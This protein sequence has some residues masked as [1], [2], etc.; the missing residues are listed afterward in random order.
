MGRELHSSVVGILGLAPTAHTLALMLHSLGAKL[1]GYD[2]A[3]HHTAPIWG[4]LNV[5]PVSQQEL[6]A[7][8]TPFRCR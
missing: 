7:M 2:P 1:V 6:L 3:V 4:R 5:Q 8:S